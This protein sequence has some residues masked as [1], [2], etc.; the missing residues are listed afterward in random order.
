MV[1]VKVM[2]V[3]PSPAVTESV[4]ALKVGVKTDGAPGFVPSSN[5]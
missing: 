5:C 1:A 2:E 3:V 4:L